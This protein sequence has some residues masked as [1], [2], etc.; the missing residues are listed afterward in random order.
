MARKTEAVSYPYI[1]V[2]DV[3]TQLLDFLLISYIDMELLKKTAMGDAKYHRKFKKTM[4]EDRSNEYKTFT[5]SNNLVEHYNV[6]NELVKGVVANQEVDE[7]LFLQLTEGDFEEALQADRSACQTNDQLFLRF[8]QLS[9]LFRFYKK[10]RFAEQYVPGVIAEMRQA[11]PGFVELFEAEQAEDQLIESLEQY[12]VNNKLYV[13]EQ[14]E[15][16]QSKLSVAEVKQQMQLLLAQLDED[17]QSKVELEE[18]EQ[19]LKAADKQLKKK[20]EQI[21]K[22]QKTVS[23][24]EREQ[25]KLQKTIDD[26]KKSDSAKALELSTAR[27]DLQKAQ[28]QEARIQQQYDNLKASFQK[29]KEK[30]CA[31]VELTYQLKVR[32]IETDSERVEKLYE[33]LQKDVQKERDE[34]QLQQDELNR[35]R[36]FHQSYIQLLEEKQQLVAANQALTAQLEQKQQEQLAVPT[37]VEEVVTE[38]DVDIFNLVSNQPEVEERNVPEVQTGEIYAVKD[39]DEIDF[40]ALLGNRPI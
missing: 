31:D 3:S 11:L 21:S 34:Q 30:A 6:Y 8:A 27:K 10:G 16:P 39:E 23:T 4:L 32:K 25:E 1:T 36:Q 29:E 33:Q 24:K 26:L 7:A 5:L 17:T 13:N 22:L 37:P 19:Q 28:E 35:L 12:M 38:I 14:Q 9:L 2:P 20:D 40:E 18:K 15:E